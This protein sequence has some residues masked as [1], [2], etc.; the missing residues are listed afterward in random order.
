MDA[1]STKFLFPAVGM[2]PIKRDV[3]KA[4]MAALTTAAELLA[5][6]QA[7]R[8]LPGGHTFAR[9]P[10]APWPQR[11]RPPGDDLR[12]A[13]HPGRS[14]RYRACPTDRYVGAEAVPRSADDR[15]R[16]TDPSA[17]LPIRRESQAPAADA[18]RRDGVDRVDDGA[19]AFDRL[20]VARAAADPRRERE[21][22]PDHDARSDGSELAARRRARRRRRVQEVR[23]LPASERSATCAAVCRRRARSPSRP[24]SSC[25][26]GS[27]PKPSEPAS[28]DDGHDMT[29]NE[30]R[31]NT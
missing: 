5:R 12:G 14:D 16:R 21:R 30:S 31:G 18:R 6:R 22:L 15:V 4:S 10:P 24:N 8:H 29:K 20:L 1:R 27:A 3:K 9:R 28:D 26:R 13:D 25:R 7:R 19:G 11:R 2:V 17:R 23:R